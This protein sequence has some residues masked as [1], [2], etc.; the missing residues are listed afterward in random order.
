VLHERAASPAW[1]TPPP[2]GGDA[3]ETDARNA[4]AEGTRTDRTSIGTL[5]VGKGRIV[6]FGALLPQPTESYDHW[7]GVDPYTVSVAGQQ[8]LL[9][10]L[11]WSDGPSAGS[12]LDRRKFSFRLHHAWRARVV[13]VKVYVNGKL[14]IARRGRNIKRVTIKR[15]PRKRFTVKIVATQSTGSTLVSTRTYNGCKKSR[16]RT[17]GIRRHR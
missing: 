14:K 1:Q 15:L 2:L 12:C 9:R 3:G 16:P 6:A 11:R 17:R 13:R 4:P 5:N 10:A 7:F 8:L